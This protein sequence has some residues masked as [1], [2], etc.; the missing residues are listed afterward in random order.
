LGIRGHD[1]VRT[2]RNDDHYSY[3]GMS[4]RDAGQRDAARRLDSPDVA[5]DVA[6]AV[7]D[8]VHDYCYDDGWPYEHPI[9]LPQLR[10][11]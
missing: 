11:L 2:H 7:N 10:H 5:V 8:D 6:V 3:S 9:E 4:A 1:L